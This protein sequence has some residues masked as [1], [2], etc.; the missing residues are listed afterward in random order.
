MEGTTGEIRLFASAFVPRDWVSCN[1]TLLPINRYTALFA[2][3]GNVYGGD[4]K[5][6]FGLPDLRGRTVVG[7]GQG[8]G[9]SPYALGQMG[10]RNN[11]SLSSANL[12]PHTHPCTAA[13][14]IPAYSDEGNSNTPGGN[15]LAALE[16]MYSDQAGDTKMKASSYTVTVST[17]GKNTPLNLNQPSLGMNY[18]IC[19]NGE[20]PPRQ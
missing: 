2:L 4:G 8:P 20:F 12:P 19:L 16:S 18:I 9:L 10:G 11:V 5:T 7:A 1:G 13:V 17:V 3:I 15:V 14:S 6:T